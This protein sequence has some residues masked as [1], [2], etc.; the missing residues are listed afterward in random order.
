MFDDFWEKKALNFISLRKSMLS[1]W[2]GG[3]VGWGGGRTSTYY[4]LS[5]DSIHWYADQFPCGVVM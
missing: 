1:L 5:I 4:V 3:G 2:G